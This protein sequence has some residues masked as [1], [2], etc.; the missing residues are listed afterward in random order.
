PEPA[1]LQQVARAVSQKASHV[2][3]LVRPVNAVVYFGVRGRPNEYEAEMPRYHELV[4]KAEA[5]VHAL[6]A[7]AGKAFSDFPVPSLPPMETP[8]RKGQSRE[9]LILPATEQEKT[10]KVAA[11]YKL[12]LFASEEQFPD[13]RNPVQIAFGPRG[14][15]WVVTMPSFPHTIPGEKPADKI[16]ILEDI[17]RDGA[18]DRQTVFADGLNVPDGLVF[19]RDGIIVSAQPRLVYMSD[20]DGDDRADHQQ[21]LLRG[22]DVTDAHHGGMIAMDPM[23]DV[24]LCDGVF[25]RSQFE[26]PTGVVRGVDA[27][28]YRFDPET[29]QL[30]SEY[31]TLT[32]NP[33]KITFDRWGNLFHMYGDG[34][35][36]DSQAIP[37]TPLGLYHPFRRAVSIAYGKGSGATVISSPNFP[38]NYQQG[39]ASATLLGNHFVAISKLDPARGLHAASAR[40][41]VISSKNAAFRP[42][43]MAFGFDGAM[44]VSDFCSTIIG[45]AQ[46]PMR[47]PRWDHRHGRIW[48]VTHTGKPLV[49]EWP[50]VA[51]AGPGELLALLSY[52]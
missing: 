2:A 36:Q 16:L 17:D 10:I 41:D 48:R 4:R 5:V 13:L 52:P 30:G 42:V 34:F 37:W 38:D 46:H 15:L 33:W 29:G 43:D 31:Q 9:G 28:T 39:M 25:H 11:G 51:G 6:A 22:I 1:R 40:L 12:N 7:D 26:T 49:T 18:A 23:G 20:T 50:E 21:E 32:P 45:H 3:T 47:D 27:T 44:Y 19:H 24:M 8:G 35:V 14:R